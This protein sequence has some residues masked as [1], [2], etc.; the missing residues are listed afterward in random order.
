MKIINLEQGTKEWLNWRTTVIT[1][2]DCPSILG[3]SPWQTKYKCWQ[4][5]LGL[6]EE[7]KS[8]FAME[9][10]KRLEPL[11]RDLFIKET[12]INMLPIVIE[13]TDYEFL[14]ASLDGISDCRRF[15]LEIKCGGEELYEKALRSEIPD[16]YRDQMQHQLLVTNAELCYYVVYSKKHKEIVIMELKPDPEFIVKFLPIAREFWKCIAYFEVPHLTDRDYQDMNDNLTWQEYSK[17]YKEVDISIKALEEK[18]DYIRRRLIE[19]CA[20]QS[21]QGSG[22][23]VIKSNVKG[24]IVYDEIPEIQGIDLEKYRKSYTVTWKILIDK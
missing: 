6:V 5:K 12:G 7:Q 23:K 9:E 17:M 18:K 15:I 20:D 22:I 11:A 13:S 3:S 8:N 14:G 2:T 16:Y 4:R 24:R 1:A 21:S 19:I 10:G